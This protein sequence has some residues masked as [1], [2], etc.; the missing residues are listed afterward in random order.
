MISV[1]LGHTKPLCHSVVKVAAAHVLNP[2]RSLQTQPQSPPDA[3][4]KGR[5]NPLGIEMLPD[6]L[7]KQ[8][9]GVETFDHERC[10]TPS[11]YY[12]QKCIQDLKKHDLL[13]KQ[14]SEIDTIYEWHKGLSHE[15]TT[16][17]KDASQT[18]A[19]DIVMDIPKLEG[20]NIDQHFQKLGQNYSSI[21][22]FMATDMIEK[23]DSIIERMPEEWSE[24]SGWT[25]YTPVEGGGFIVEQ[26]SHPEEDTLVFDV[27]TLVQDR[28]QHSPTMAVALSSKAWYSWTSSRMKHYSDFEKDETAHK[29]SVN[30]LIPFNSSQNKEKLI[31]GH[32][33]GFDRSFLSDQ[34]KLN[35]NKTKFLDTLSLHMCICGLTGLQ[36]NVKV[37]D[38]R[39]KKDE[40]LVE[41]EELTIEELKDEEAIV[42]DESKD[43]GWMENSSLNNLADVYQHH[44]GK[45]ISKD[46]RDVFV[47]GTMEEVREDFQSLMTYCANDVK[48]TYEVFKTIFPK[49]LHRFPHPVTLAG[50]LEM[51]TM[52][53]PLNTNN[54]FK[55][56]E[57]SQNTY[58]EFE[59]RMSYALQELAMR[60]CSKTE[61]E[62]S[63]DIWLWDLDWSKQSIKSNKKRLSD[64]EKKRSG[65]DLNSKSLDEQVQDIYDTKEFMQAKA[66]FLPGF[67]KWYRDLC[68]SFPKTSSKSTDKSSSKDWQPGPCLI[69]TRMNVTPRLMQMTW[70]GYPLHYHETYKWGYLVPND[71]PLQLL[72]LPEGHPYE[73]FPLQE[74]KNLCKGLPKPHIL[75]DDDSGKNSK[76]EEDLVREK[77][78]KLRDNTQDI[79]PALINLLK[80]LS[81]KKVS[82]KFK[83]EYCADVDI[84]GAYFIRLPHA[85]GPNNVGSPLG[86]DFIPKMEN[87]TLSSIDNNLISLLLNHSCSISYWQNNQNRIKNQMVVS[88]D[89]Q[90]GAILPRVITAGTVTRRAV[91]TTWLTASNQDT[92]RIGSELKAMIQAPDGYCFVGADVDSQELWIASLIGDS[93][94]YKIHG[95]TGLSYMTLRGSKSEKTDMHSKTASLIGITRSEA[96]V[97]NYARIYG[98]G[99][100]F[101]ERFLM[102]TNQQLSLE[103]AKE[104]SETI[105]KE[106]KGVRRFHYLKSSMHNS[107]KSSTSNKD[108]AISIP[109]DIPRS[110]KKDLRLVWSG[111]TESATFNKLEEIAN[112][113]EPRTP[114]LDC[115]ISQALE[116]DQAKDFGTSRVN[117]VVQSSAVDFLHLVLVNM[118]WLFDRLKIDGRFSISIHDEVRYLVK[119]EDKYKAAFAL[120]VSNLLVR[121]YFAYKLN[122]K[123][124]PISVAFFSSVDIDKCLR[125]EVDMDCKSPSNPYG[126]SE[127]YNIPY[128]ESLDMKQTLRKYSYKS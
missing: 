46:K 96:K 107:L 59:Q 48:A 97:L 90:L 38:K 47:K 40:Q 37:T 110:D 4:Y 52:Y 104:K 43:N 82:P 108:K 125:K 98:A 42:T 121:A 89:D 44:C 34:Y 86:R 120:Q 56:I 12:L 50:M 3:P 123:D 83:N 66:P 49:F 57:N 95:G 18:A 6:K 19:D 54:W 127:A 80:K 31:I 81:K 99:R 67:P 16:P 33:V 26:V 106:T 23:A 101:I 118:K 13:P 128:G 17:A 79:T 2:F 7:Y 75:I 10:V 87:G 21:Y 117:W 58:N 45:M 51:S 61:E 88:V 5:Y 119:E 53:L 9:F 39:R 27:E 62:H 115:Q 14:L 105:L 122:M 28:I 73:K 24:Q 11:K 94:S 70:N 20:N 91:E 113:S 55:Y 22:K 72:K 116:P 124:L 84:P 109:I 25:K 69:T 8:V 32:N 1:A 63:K 92:T 77:I 126:L 65:T 68:C 41:S 71:D 103:E 29:L 85:K 100:K 78:E 112:S 74:L 30:D 60:E 15:S 111:G 102:N 36:R 64:W 76:L 114:V 93:Y 35:P